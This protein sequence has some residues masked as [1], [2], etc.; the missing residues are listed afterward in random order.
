MDSLRLSSV[1]SSMV[2]RAL[3]LVAASFLAA[4]SALAWIPLF[5]VKELTVRTGEQ[6][7]VPVHAAWS[8]LD[9]TFTQ[10]HFEFISADESVAFVE[11]V[12]QNPNPDAFVTITGIGP[13]D[14]SVRVH[15]NPDW[16]WLTIHVECGTEPA[17]IAAKPVV[18]A[19]QGQTVSL[20]AITPSSHTVFLWYFG[21]LGDDSHP[22]TNS[23][24]GPELRLT[25]AIFGANYVW[26]MARTSCSESMA[27]FRI[28]VAALRRR[29]TG[30]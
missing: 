2:N 8:G 26:V 24:A 1:L 20:Q 7:K 4:S 13:G 23:G 28:D 18:T 14:T 15:Q 9:T 5:P 10:Y 11:G 27:V 3:L 19:T 6:I 12:L 22:I 30:H 25:A 29:S 16:S 21:R 17:V